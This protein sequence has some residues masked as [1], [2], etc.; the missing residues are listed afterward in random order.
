[1]GAE[2]LVGDGW[3]GGAFDIGIV[4]GGTVG[5]EDAAVDFGHFEVGVNVLFNAD[6]MVV[7]VEVINALF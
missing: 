7:A 5:L 1:M 4:D 2:L 6:E 3:E